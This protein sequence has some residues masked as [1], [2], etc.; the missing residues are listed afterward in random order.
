MRT[1]SLALR[2]AG[3]SA[4]LVLAALA[5]GSGGCIGAPWGSR[6]APELRPVFDAINSRA[7]GGQLDADIWTAPDPDAYGR[8][9]PGPDG[10]PVIVV[11][12]RLSGR[13]LE[14]V[15]AHEMVHVALSGRFI[16]N[17]VE[18]GHGPAFQSECQR[19]ASCLGLPVRMLVDSPDP[20][21]TAWTRR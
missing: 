19:V 2:T 10:R 21:G 16:A 15:L 14:A 9:M 5:T 12:N 11:D 6:P 17:L 13:T 20:L 3:W 8:T 4:T 7:F 18:G 1:R